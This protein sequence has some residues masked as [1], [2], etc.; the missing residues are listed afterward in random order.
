DYSIDVFLRQSWVDPRLRYNLT[1]PHFTI[2]DPR[3]RKKIWKPDT[4][5]N[6]V[7]DAKVHQVTM[8]N[9]LIRVH[10]TVRFSI[11]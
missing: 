10:K 2:T 3:I 11:V 8:P 1:R 9:I 7:K 5:F 4:Y 6:N